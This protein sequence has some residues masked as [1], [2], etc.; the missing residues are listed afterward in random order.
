M[1][2]SP[3][4]RPALEAGVLIT[5]WIPTS[6]CGFEELSL[7]LIHI[8]ELDRQASLYPPCCCCSVAKLCPTLYDPVDCS[9]PSL[10]VP[11]HLQ[12]FAQVHVHWTGD[13][14]QPSHPLLPSSPFAF[15]LSHLTEGETCPEKLNDLPK[16]AKPMRGVLESVPRSNLVLSPTK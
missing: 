3:L 2:S 13:P 10:P 12:E 14:I 15:N 7:S 9:T 16:V 6:L 8:L 11:Y 4:G 1:A 5:P